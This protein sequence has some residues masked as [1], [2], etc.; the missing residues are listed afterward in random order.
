MLP[1]SARLFLFAAVLACAHAKAA[2]A[3]RFIAADEPGACAGGR[4]A[5]SEDLSTFAHCRTVTGDLTIDRTDLTDL[6]ALSELRLVTGALTIQGNARLRNLEGLERLERV[7][8]LELRSNG[9]YGTHG[10]ESLRA[11]GRLVIA[12][13]PFLISLHGFS[14]LERVDTLVVSHNP[15]IAAQLGLFP[16]LRLGERIMALH[17][18]RG[19]SH[20]EVAQLIAFAHRSQP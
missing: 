7:G 5:S 12:D 16:S 19:L 4:I 8:A 18:N 3:P 10:I 2:P 17:A 11:V 9:L 13:H 20:D 6:A 14:K 15:R 1:K